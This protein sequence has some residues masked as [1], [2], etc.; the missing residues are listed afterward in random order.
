MRN[1]HASATE[2][3]MKTIRILSTLILG[4]L[5]LAATGCKKSDAA[6]GGIDGTWTG[7]DIADPNAKCQLTVGNGTL[8]FHGTN[9][10]DSFS[11]TIANIYEESKPCTLDV[12]L[13]APPDLANKTGLFIFDRTG[14]DLKLAWAPL[15]TFR[16]PVDFTPSPEV[17]VVSLKRQ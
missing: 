3:D 4:G 11:G 14:D 8:E 16:R 1:N 13:T 2:L 12:N 6:G 9:D 5:L 15:G 10:S 7:S 17:R